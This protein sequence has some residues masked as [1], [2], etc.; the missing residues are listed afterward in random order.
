M[1]GTRLVRVLYA[2]A[3][4]CVVQSRPAEGVGTAALNQRQLRRL[5]HEQPSSFSPSG[6]AAPNES[7]LAGG[8]CAVVSEGADTEWTDEEEI[9]ALAQCLE[10]VAA[11]LNT[12]MQMRD[13]AEWIEDGSPAVRVLQQVTARLAELHTMDE[14]VA[15]AQVMRKFE[16]MATEARAELD[17]SRA[18]GA[19]NNNE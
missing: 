17:R 18:G 2:V 15:R 16:E 19:T 8:A 14:T 6:S 3:L 12:G 7:P 5:S 4:L 11:V 1:A 13:R 10:S 9:T